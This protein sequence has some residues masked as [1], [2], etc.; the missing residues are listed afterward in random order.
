MGGAPGRT[1]EG[2]PEPGE[3]EERR[4]GPGAEG[5]CRGAAGGFGKGKVEDHRLPVGREAD[6]R[7][8]A[9]RRLQ[10]E[11]TEAERVTAVAGRIDFGGTDLAGDR[12][13]LARGAR[14]EGRVPGRGE[15]ARLAGSDGVGVQE[16]TRWQRKRQFARVTVRHAAGEGAE[17]DAD[18]ELVGME[19]RL[20]R[21]GA[22]VGDRP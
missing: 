17:V 9:G 18:I 10:V 4:Q 5:K 8:D 7:G 1:P 13:A 12:T 16:Q 2:E 19:A 21:R 22:A 3:V 15:F 14:F 20:G 11:K 6:L